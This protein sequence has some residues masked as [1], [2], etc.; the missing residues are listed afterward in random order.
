MATPATFGPFSDGSALIGTISNETDT[1]GNPLS[2]YTFKAAPTWTVS[3]A[4]I[5]QLGAPA[6]GSLSIPMTALKPGAAVITVV[7][8]GVTVTAN[9][10]VIASALGGFTVTIALAPPAPPPAA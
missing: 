2:G 1:T 7:G 4:T 6:S 8:D 10:T 3:D 9:V 5:I